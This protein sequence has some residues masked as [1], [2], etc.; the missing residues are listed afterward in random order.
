MAIKTINGFVFSTV[1]QYGY[2]IE[3]LSEY[4]QTMKRYA[5]LLIE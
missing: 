1:K 2:P 4:F 5:F 3:V